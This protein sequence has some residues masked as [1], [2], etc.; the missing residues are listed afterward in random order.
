MRLNWPNRIT[1]GRILAVPVFAIL[2]LRIREPEV[3]RLYRLLALVLFLLVGLADV[4]DGWLARRLRQRTRLGSILDPLADKMLLTIACV[5]LAFPDVIDTSLPGWLAVIVVSRD[6]FIVV[7]SLV[8]YLL[9]GRLHV[10]V[11]RVARASTLSVSL[12]VIAALGMG[13]LPPSAQ[14]WGRH[15]LTVLVHVAGTL[16]VASG[17]VYGWMARGELGA[18]AYEPAEPPLNGP[19]RRRG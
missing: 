18:A 10:R 3:G 8:L 11:T 2:V 5:L 12:T 16:V 1:L 17:L 15:V 14:A 13:L 19:S 4:V 9:I 6:V 7:G